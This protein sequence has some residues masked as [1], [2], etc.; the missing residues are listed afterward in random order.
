MRVVLDSNVLL[1]ALIS[2]H[3]PPQLIYSAWQ[4]SRHCLPKI[5][6][7]GAPSGP[8]GPDSRPRY[9]RLPIQSPSRTTNSDRSQSSGGPGYRVARHSWSK[10]SP[11][12]TETLLQPFSS[13]IGNSKPC[14]F[15]SA[16]RCAVFKSSA[17]ISAHISRAVISGT[18]PS[19]SRA[20]VGSPRSVSTSAGRK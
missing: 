13:G 18:Q 6:W 14:S 5:T 15:M 7:P 4:K 8:A 12:G 16:W 20:L 19:F 11:G 10:P 1:S 3:A 2:P 9:L 17:T